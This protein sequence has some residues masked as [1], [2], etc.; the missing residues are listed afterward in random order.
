M[1]GLIVFWVAVVCCVVLV[2]GFGLALSEDFG[3]FGW[4][5]TVV[6]LLVLGVGA[7]AI[8]DEAFVPHA[9]FTL[10]TDRWACTGRHTEIVNT[11]I[12]DGKGGGHSQV[13]S[14]TVCDQYSRIRA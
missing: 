5:G 4:V 14:Y 8:Y 9:T 11:W 7:A 13:S 1:I 3:L 12:S 6:M 2:I 10:R